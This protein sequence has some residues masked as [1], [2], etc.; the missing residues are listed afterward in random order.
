[1]DSGLKFVL[2]MGISIRRTDLIRVLFGQL[3]ANSEHSH[4]LAQPLVATV[5]PFTIGYSSFGLQNLGL[6]IDS[7]TIKIASACMKLILISFS[8]ENVKP[9]HV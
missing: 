7:N 9:S 1:M 8:S 6:N 4:R 2:K 5:L 3:W